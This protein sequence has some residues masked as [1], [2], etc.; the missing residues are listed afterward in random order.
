MTIKIQFP[1]EFH[2][3]KCQTVKTNLNND[4]ETE[5]KVNAQKNT[6]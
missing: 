6:N 1:L 2:T 5:K 3:F 4:T